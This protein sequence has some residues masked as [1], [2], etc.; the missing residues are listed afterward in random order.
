[1]L[2]GKLISTIIVRALPLRETAKRSFDG[3]LLGKTPTANQIEFINPIVGLGRGLP[4]LWV[5][6]LPCI[7]I[8]CEHATVVRCHGWHL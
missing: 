7:C 2:S 6:H 1:M 5:W 3:F 4:F 8:R